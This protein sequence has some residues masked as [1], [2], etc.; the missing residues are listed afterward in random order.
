[1]HSDPKLHESLFVNLMDKDNLPLNNNNAINSKS[2]FY[3]NY[4]NNSTTNNL[5]NGLMTSSNNL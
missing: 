3:Q 2:L 4:M 5:Q 1:M